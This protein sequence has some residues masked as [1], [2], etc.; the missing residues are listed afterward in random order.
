MRVV[1]TGASGFLGSALVRQ[2][3]RRG[4]EVVGVARRGGPGLHAV[5]RYADA[6]AGDVLVHLAET[7]DRRQ[8]EA[9]GAE[10]EQEASQTLQT[11]IGKRYARVVYA[12]SAV[13]YGDRS[14]MPH[15]TDD[16]V[17]VND[18]Y[19][20]IKFGSEQTV[21]AAGGIVARLANL[22][23][24]GMSSANVLTAILLQLDTTGPVRV[25]DAYPVRDFLW[26]EDAAAALAEMALAP[27]GTGTFNVGTG[28]GTS[29]RALA[30]IALNAVGQ[31]ERRVE[32]AATKD[33]GSRLI[34][35]IHATTSRFGWRPGTSLE[36]G[37]KT[38]VKFTRDQGTS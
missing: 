23:G 2:L 30:Q 6:P 10:Y 31:P 5:S 34:V 21:L 36:S 4:A 12:S 1:V 38:L 7:N 11:L 35:D 14:A 8:A 22:Y 33:G 28:I 24:P 26:A 29:I 20:R 27:D 19:T 16:P 3:T 32:S 17:Q 25:L 9:G 15:K 37:I 18:V 13:L